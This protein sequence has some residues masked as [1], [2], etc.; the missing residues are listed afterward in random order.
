LFNRPVSDP[1]CIAAFEPGEDPARLLEE[2]AL[3]L[4]PCSCLPG[5]EVKWL[6]ALD[7]YAATQKFPRICGDKLHLGRILA[8]NQRLTFSPIAQMQRVLVS[9]NQG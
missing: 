4:R 1:L 8:I 3:A 6:T 7:I 2:E 5:S 9:F